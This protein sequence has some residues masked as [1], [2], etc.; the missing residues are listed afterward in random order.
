LP[1]TGS[2]RAALAS[3]SWISGGGKTATKLRTRV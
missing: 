3:A 1:T 2:P